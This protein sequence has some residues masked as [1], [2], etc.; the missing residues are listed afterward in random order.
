M[1]NPSLRSEQDLLAEEVFFETCG[2]RVL[3]AIRRIIR[4]VDLHSRKLSSDYQ[5]TAPQM[6]CL[7]SLARQGEMTLSVLAKQVSLSASTV[8]GIVD[9]LEKRGLVQRQRCEKD[10]RRVHVSI[11]P[12]GQKL[13]QS[14]PALLQHKLAKALHALPEIEQQAI[15]NSLERVVELMSASELAASPN[16]L[17]S[18]NIE[19][20]GTAGSINHGVES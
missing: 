9:R 10:R 7:Y 20:A 6:V 14:A 18:A 15:A 1:P 2:I 19:E 17:P 12:E 4:A 5:I 16:L 11:S 3:T 8:N 13:T